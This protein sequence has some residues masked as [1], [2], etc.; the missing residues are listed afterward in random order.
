MLILSYDK[1]RPL[2]RRYRIVSVSKY[3]D[4]ICHRDRTNIKC[5]VIFVVFLC[6]Y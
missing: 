5:H 2:T 6:D 3:P 4:R 1:L